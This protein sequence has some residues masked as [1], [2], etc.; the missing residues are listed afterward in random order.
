MNLFIDTTNWNLIIL[1]EKDGQVID[2]VIKRNTKKVSDIF[3]SSLNELLSKHQ[4]TLREIEKLYV[5]TGPGSY[6][7]V[8]IGLLFVKT[9]KTIDD[10]YQTYVINSLAYQAGLAKVVS[11]LDARGQKFFV[12]VYENGKPLIEEQLM[13]QTE[14]DTLK[15]KYLFPIVADY[16]DLDFA[17]NFL[18]LKENFELINDYKNLLPVYLKKP[19]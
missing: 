3:I 18:E 15:A 16:Q 5:T 13:T 8:R 1:L 19:V 2:S 11:I 12:G 6:T 14:L 7:G 10:H 9:L 17:K 4:L